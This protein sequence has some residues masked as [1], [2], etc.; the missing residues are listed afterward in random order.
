VPNPARFKINDVTFGASSVDVLF[1]LRRE[2]FTRTGREEDPMPMPHGDDIGTDVMANLCRH[3]IQ[4]RR[5]DFP[6]LG[7]YP[8][9]QYGF[10]TASTR[11]SL[12]R[13]TSHMK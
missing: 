10:I 11:Y 6:S 3:L 12:H 8:I 9:N 2:E 5:Y 13:K 7:S 1:H 4:Q